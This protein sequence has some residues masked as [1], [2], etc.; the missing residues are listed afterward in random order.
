MG[1]KEERLK[2]DFIELMQEK[3][4]EI[5]DELVKLEARADSATDAAKVK[6]REKIAELKVERDKLKAK[7][8]EL[9][10][11]SD[12]AWDELKIGLERSWSEIT[13]GLKNAFSKFK[14][15]KKEGEEGGGEKE[16]ETTTPQ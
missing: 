5:D 7:T 16:D 6:T 15:T 13:A 2:K 8:K 12:A 11:T 3:F 14:E 10:E 1:E 4:K 9:M